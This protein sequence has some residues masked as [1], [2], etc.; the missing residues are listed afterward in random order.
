MN[1]DTLLSS[2]ELQHLKVATK[3]PNSWLGA[4]RLLWLCLTLLV[5]LILSEIWPSN[6]WET[7]PEW[8]VSRAHATFTYLIPYNNFVRLVTLIESLSALTS[9]L[10]GF[11]LFWYK[12]HDKMGLFASA[13]LILSAPWL[14]SS[15]MEIWRLPTWIP[16]GDSLIEIIMAA[17]LGSLILF[18]YIFPDGRFVPR[19]T[20]WTAAIILLPFG[21]FVISSFL[22]TPSPF[23]GLWLL[24][25]T[26]VL[27]SLV[28]AAGAQ[29]YR[30]HYHTSL[31]QRQQIKW[32]ILGLELYVLSFMPTLFGIFFDLPN[33][34][35][36]VELFLRL[37]A[38]WLL[39]LTIGFSILR[40]RLWEIDLLLNRA[41]VYGLLT[42]LVV[43]GYVLVVG[44]LSQWLPLDG[45]PLAAALVIGLVAL[46][47][48]PLRRRLQRGVNRLMYGQQDDPLAVLSQLGQ[49]LAVTGKPEEMLPA[50]TETISRTLALPY[51]SIFAQD[52]KC[53]AQ[54]GTKMPVTL[55]L[56][57]PYQGETVGQLTVSG[58]LSPL[59]HTLLTQIAGQAGAV[60][61][62]VQLTADLQSSRQQIITAR[63]E[64]RRRLSRDLHDGLGPQLA[65]LS[66]KLDAARNLLS[67]N[68]HQADQLLSELK[69]Q[70]QIAIADIRRLV[71]DL[72]PPALDQLG[73][74]SAIQEQINSHILK[75]GLEISL[76]T[77]PTLPWLPAAVELAA[78]RIVTE[79]LHNVVRH[80]EASHCI[81][82]L[83]VND[84]LKIEI[85]DDG[86]GIPAGTSPGIGLSSI[87][88]RANE[89]GGSCH[90]ESS[91]TTGTQIFVH[92]PL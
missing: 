59:G 63:E 73:L 45:K 5:L 92:L 75:N 36:L 17:T 1:K 21:H 22:N 3:A 19:W 89:L 15:N 76:E 58:E 86:Q 28:L 77:P 16:F 32:I 40:Y 41:T 67:R 38:Q 25:T 80:A 91:S 52:G 4:A 61:Y 44:A 50:L 30:Y 78:Y 49:R 85:Q 64:E 42:V 18:F 71:Y 82:R 6:F 48:E 62:A 23:E 13:F 84:S 54:S 83:T 56:P 66:I 47:F 14:I 26:T 27:G 70:T 31:I 29:V 87:R 39:P 60:V 55:S 69:D 34:S 37:I 51:V 53:L 79:A 9:L 46:L 11:L 88:E 10:V 90:L 20:R 24:Y 57:L 8:V 72:R 7:Y 12:S 65:S 33:W 35:I 43:G 2:T 81:V 68:P 74:I